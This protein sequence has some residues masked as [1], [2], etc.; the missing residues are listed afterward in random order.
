MFSDGVHD[1]RSKI[2]LYDE[3]RGNTWK[4]FSNDS[5]QLCVLGGHFPYVFENHRCMNRLGDDGIHSG[6]PSRNLFELEECFKL[7]SLLLEQ[8]CWREKA[9]GTSSVQVPVLWSFK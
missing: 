1:L 5:R 6:L 2:L 9:G 3:D 7:L 8:N 4:I